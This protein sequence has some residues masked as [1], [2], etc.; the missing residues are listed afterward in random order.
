MKGVVGEFFEEDGVTPKS[1]V[2][3]KS[4]PQG[5]STSLMAAFTPKVA[6]GSYFADCQ[7]GIVKGVEAGVSPGLQGTFVDPY[8]LDKAAA[9]KLWAVTEQMVGENF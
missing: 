7:P 3:V 8:A 9:K 2:F 4:I 1:C 6:N 5:A